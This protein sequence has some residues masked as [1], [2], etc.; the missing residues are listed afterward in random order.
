MNVTV[1]QKEMLL[2]FLKRNPELVRGR[3]DRKNE[4]R[5]KLFKLWDEV[6]Q[7]INTIIEGPQKSG[8]EWAKTWKDMKSYIL[9][10]EAKRRNYMQGTGGEPLPKVAFS[11]FEEQV[12]ELLTPEAAG[13]ENIPEGGINTEE[14]PISESIEVV[15]TERA[16]QD[17]CIVIEEDNG[18]QE[19][20]I[21]DIENIPLHNDTEKRRKVYTSENRK[22]TI[23]G[24]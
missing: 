12:L 3:I 6:A 22:N 16:E 14:N 23:R 15:E 7:G 5:L 9:K 21:E 17:I 2:N 18:N 8:K 20:A 13:L 24:N 10:K 19:N 4:S 1:K 11:V